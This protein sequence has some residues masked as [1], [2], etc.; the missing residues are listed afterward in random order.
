MFENLTSRFSKILDGVFGRKIITE[1]D[2]NKVMREIR[3]ALLEADV[4]L[5][6]V[7]EFVNKIKEKALGQDVIKSVNPGQM[8][9]KLVDDEIKDLL[10]SEKSELNLQTKAPA[11]IMMTGLQG[12][13]KTTSSGKLAKYLKDKHNKKVLLAS[14]DIYRPAA[15]KQLEVLGKQVNADTVDIIE[16]QGVIEIA[17][18]TF[19]QAQEKY[20]DI[21]ILDTAG[22][23][24]I[25]NELM[26]E[27]KEVKALTNPVETLLVADSLTGQDS[28]NIAKTFN[29]EIGV[30]GIILTR[31]DGDG[32]GGA[33]LSMKMVTGRPIKFIGVG[34]KVNEFEEFYPERISSRILGMGDVVSLVEKAQEVVDEKEAKKLEE[35]MRKGR[36]D[37][38]DLL[39]QLKMLKKM[40]GLGSLISFLPGAGKLKDAMGAKGLDG[41]G[42]LLKKQE[43]MILSMTEVERSNPDIMSSSRK[44]R[45]IAGSGTT[46]QEINSLLKKYKQMNKMM[47]KMK[48]MNPNQL[49]GMM[50][51]MNGGSMNRMDDFFK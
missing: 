40:G 39:K 25:D 4:S 12:S 29:D 37:F 21:L 6:V 30:T 13:G 28:V 34:E 51:D 15:Q 20:Y 5:P 19:K 16:G 38:N 26:E 18:R 10:G 49:K 46:I 42:G 48:G 3:I 33:A 32:R 14:L 47:K 1:D 8:I 24:H 50:K 9:V 31:I 23:L 36:F 44:R 11:V 35:K 7:K 27:L 45:I 41:A 43:A 22:R 17:K 2:L